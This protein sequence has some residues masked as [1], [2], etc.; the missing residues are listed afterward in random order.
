MALLDHRGK[1]HEIVR[2]AQSGWSAVRGW[3]LLLCAGLVLLAATPS[4][5][6]LRTA[7]EYEVKAAYLYNLAKFVEWPVEAL[8]AGR[9]AIV[10]CMVS[11]ENFADTLEAVVAQK[12]AQGRALR[13]RRLEDGGSA[14]GCQMV[15]F[16]DTGGGRIPRLLAQ[17][18]QAP[19]LTVGE[20]QGFAEQ[21]GMI[22]F[23]LE[24]NKVRFEANAVAAAAAGLKVSSRLLSLA[25]IVE[26]RRA[27]KAR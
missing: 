22:N 1:R 19:V 24:N 3:A 21:G 6:H 25:R 7:S 5:A 12:T 20:S 4:T 26:S 17:L 11:G 10:I 13:V 8:P 2:A 27:G 18:G 15:F 23:Y 9:D 16:T 14:E